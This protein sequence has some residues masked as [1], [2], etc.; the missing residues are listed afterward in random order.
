MPEAKKFARGRST[1]LSFSMWV[2]K[3]GPLTLNR[4]PLGVS[5]YHCA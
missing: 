1:F 4:K 3:R 5:W 2:M